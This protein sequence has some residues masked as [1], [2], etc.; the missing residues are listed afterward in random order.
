[1]SILYSRPY[2]VEIVYSLSMASDVLTS[3]KCTISALAA[4]TPPALHPRRRQVL[5]YHIDNFAA[6]SLF[7]V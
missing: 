2:A 6:I 5:G 7:A 1:M 3:I 4:T